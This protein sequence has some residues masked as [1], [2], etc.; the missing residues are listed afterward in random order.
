MDQAC[1]DGLEEGVRISEPAEGHGGA[2]AERIA[3][4]EDFHPGRDISGGEG[5][6][7]LQFGSM[8]FG[9]TV[10][11]DIHERAVTDEVGGEF[12]EIGGEN[13][14]VLL[15]DRPRRW[16][17]FLRGVSCSNHVAISQV[18]PGSP[19]GD[20]PR[21]LRSALILGVFQDADRGSLCSVEDILCPW[22]RQ[23]GE[24]RQQNFQA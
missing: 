7:C 8:R 22:F 17:V 18:K 24:A 13:A 4:G 14:N 23:G 2:P 15:D 19:D 3:H 16:V 20:P 11:H 5:R 10:K 1:F 9:D 12:M 21:F 6:P